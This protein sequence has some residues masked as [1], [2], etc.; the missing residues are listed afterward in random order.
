M[1]ITGWKLVICWEDDT[2][3]DI[4][5]CH[6]P[7]WVADRIDTYLDREEEYYEQHN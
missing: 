6:L 5:A 4:K 3:E 1:K 7:D 2:V